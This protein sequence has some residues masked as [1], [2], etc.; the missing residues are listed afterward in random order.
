MLNWVMKHALVDVK[1]CIIGCGVRHALLNEKAR[2]I[3]YSLSA[4]RESRL[5]APK[6]L[7][8]NRYV[9]TY[10]PTTVLGILNDVYSSSSTSF[11]VDHP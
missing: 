1:S 5:S 10:P 8:K 7:A 3:G 9:Y 2:F 4:L 6:T 11:N